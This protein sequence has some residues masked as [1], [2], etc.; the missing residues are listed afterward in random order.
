MV[1][2]SPRGQ[3]PELRLHL[4]FRLH[5]CNYASYTVTGRKLQQLQQLQ[6]L[7]RYIGYMVHSTWQRE[8]V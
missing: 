7:H 4:Q 2:T 1:E 6:Q 5:S 3:A 8:K